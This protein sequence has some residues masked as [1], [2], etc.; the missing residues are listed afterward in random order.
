MVILIHLG[1]LKHHW[2]EITVTK[3]KALFELVGIQTF[4]PDIPKYPSLSLGSLGMI[5]GVQALRMVLE[6][7]DHPHSL[8]IRMRLDHSLLLQSK[9]PIGL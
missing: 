7:H 3:S 8:Y 9:D 1:M 5:Q 2:F 6:R 4:R